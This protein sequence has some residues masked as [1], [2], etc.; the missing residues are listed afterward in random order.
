MNRVAYTMIGGVEYPL[1]LSVAAVRE[2]D[3]E[4]G[5]IEQAIDHVMSE[6]ATALSQLDFVVNMFSILIRQGCTYIRLTEGREITPLEKGNLES[7][8]TLAD[9]EPC[10]DDLM[11]ALG[12]GLEQTVEIEPTKETKQKNAK[13]TQGV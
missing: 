4:Y 5:G 8:I 6:E 9:L 2:I 12:L 3:A 10:F 13:P 1:V 7:L 11:K